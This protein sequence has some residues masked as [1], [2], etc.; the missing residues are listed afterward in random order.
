MRSRTL[1]EFSEDTRRLIM[2]KARAR[3]E[4]ETLVARTLREILT[5]QGVHPVSVDLMKEAV[6]VVVDLS[7]GDPRSYSNLSTFV[8]HAIYRSLGL[9]SP[10]D[11]VAAACRAVSQHLGGRTVLL[12]LDEIGS[13][14]DDR[15]R[16]MLRLPEAASAQKLRY[17][18]MLNL[19]E[20]IDYT[21]GNLEGEGRW[22]VY[23]TGRNEWLAM[24]ALAGPSSPL[25]TKAV[26]LAPLT[27]KDVL[28]MIQGTPSIVKLFEDAAVRR[29]LADE[30][31]RR[32]GGVGRVIYTALQA[33]HS[34]GNADTK[35]V[36]KTIRLVESKLMR[37]ASCLFPRAT[38]QLSD[39]E[40]PALLSSIGRLLL[41]GQPF[42]EDAVM[43]TKNNQPVLTSSV[44][45]D[46]GF[47]FVPAPN[48]KDAR[49]LLPMA[50]TWHL[51]ALPEVLL[52]SDGAEALQ[53]LHA[54]AR[55][56]K[57]CGRGSYFEALCIVQTIALIERCVPKSGRRPFGDIM[58]FLR[59]TSAETATVGR[60]R[61]RMLPKVTEQTKPL[62]EVQ[63]TSDVLISSLETI[64]PR[65]LRWF[66]YKVL[67]EDELGIP[68]GQSASQ[69]WFIRAKGAVVGFC[70]KLVDRLTPRNVGS[71][72]KKRPTFVQ[73]DDPYVLV[74]LCAALGPK[75]KIEMSN[76]AAMVPNDMAEGEGSSRD[77]IVVSPTHK[78]G[79]DALL[80][81]DV[82]D[83][84]RSS[85]ASDDGI[86]QRW[87]L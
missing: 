72:L 10:P 74:V 25:R 38:T 9:P 45:T 61:P 51:M 47:N 29:Q 80:T 26:L 81:I 44:L 67:G 30:I 14:V 13:L 17:T 12:V 43:L 62:T 1:S 71:E 28:E 54:L 20:V 16:H 39:I 31:A 66:L 68:R 65:D 27:A 64:N 55:A 11:G 69:D 60:L 33:L 77:V 53:L 46:L 42:E 8:S 4:D 49:L 15:Y 37:A 50:G 7:T 73:G 32:S 85:A 36:D 18:A 5:R 3:L 34:C 6:T 56:E 86:L 22:M 35:N 76:K 63:K 24:H 70:S 79:L 59:G 75:L 41:E 52:R 19:R 82:G 40:D 58:P 78:D 87:F 48:S 21:C 2:S 83:R 84:F 23:C 57:G